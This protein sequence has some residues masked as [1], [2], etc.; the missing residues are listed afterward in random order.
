VLGTAAAA[1]EEEEE[2]E[3]QG[4]GTKKR[5]RGA[6]ESSGR[7]TKQ[8]KPDMGALFFEGY[9]WYHGIN[10]RQKDMLRGQLMIE[11][12]ADAGVT[13][14]KAYCFRVGRGGAQ[15]DEAEAFKRFKELAEGDELHQAIAMFMVGDCYWF[16]TGVDM[17]SEWLQMGRTAMLFF[18]DCYGEGRV[19]MV[20]L[21]QSVLLFE[22]LCLLTALCSR[23]QLKELVKRWTNQ[24][25][26]SQTRNL[27]QPSNRSIDGR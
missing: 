11:V 19:V 20:S 18:G 3:A 23:S 22:C 8:A 24:K 17:A 15:P 26:A 27:N 9:E 25:Q 1:E 21:A 6:K 5:K 14:A 12:A 7:A 10:S 2:E 4:G 16:G 13:M